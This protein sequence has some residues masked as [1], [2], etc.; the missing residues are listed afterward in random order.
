[1]RMGRLSFETPQVDLISGVM[2]IS[3][4]KQSAMGTARI[5]WRHRRAVMAIFALSMLA[6]IALLIVLPPTYTARA[7]IQIDVA[8]EPAKASSILGDTPSDA[9]TSLES[10]T[11]VQSEAAIMK[12]PLIIRRAVEH[13]GLADVPDT[14]HPD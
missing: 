2:P 13:L 7:T 5:A 8:R 11:I 4:Y 10:S 12:S 9:A 3:D 14:G 1:M 6:A